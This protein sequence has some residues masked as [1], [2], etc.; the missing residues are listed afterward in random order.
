M[1]YGHDEPS[2]IQYNMNTLKEH[3]KQIVQSKNNQSSMSLKEQKQEYVN[4]LVHSETKISLDEFFK[5]IHQKFYPKQDMFFMEYFLELV[6]HEGEFYVHHDK[7][8]EFGVMSSTRSSSTDDKLIALG[9]KED[10]DYLQ[11][12]M[13]HNLPSSVVRAKIYRLT[14]EAFKK[15]LMRAQTNSNQKVDPV[16]FAD[17]FLLL[18]NTHLLFTEY[19]KKMMKN[20]LDQKDIQLEQKD[21]QL[22][23]KEQELE[24]QRLHTLDLEEGLRNDIPELEKTQIIYIATS[25][26]YAKRN[27]FK[28]GGVDHENKLLSRLSENTGNKEHIFFYTN[29][30]KVHDYREAESR[31]KK[32]V[33]KFR[34]RKQK[35][36]YRL[37]YDNLVHILG[38]IVEHFNVEIDDVNT[39][40][41]TFICNL[42]RYDRPTPVVPLILNH[43]YQHDKL[44]VVLYTDTLGNL[45]EKTPDQAKTL[46][47]NTNLK[48][49]Q[50]FNIVGRIKG[51]EI[52]KFIYPRLENLIKKTQR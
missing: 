49:K 32:L 1:I 26:N 44:P 46:S 14:P 20:Q 27:L 23:Q 35:E 12:E 11:Q 18:E 29:I 47:K 19:E 40:L 25:H 5:N 45:M 51:N 41:E 4:Q 37:C 43:I 24:K 16:I 9:L 38:Y 33:G 15:C 42:N 17:Y 13:L 3:V 7:L 6:N 10:R 48:A 50:I 36:M 52:G 34:D 2:K 8:V 30:Y 28:V 21:I 39:N 22:E 31:L